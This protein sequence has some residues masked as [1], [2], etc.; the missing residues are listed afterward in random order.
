MIQSIKQFF[1]NNFS[2]EK[3]TQVPLEEKLN[4]AAAA[5]LIE[6]SYSDMNISE[7]ENKVLR[8]ILKEKFH[9]NETLVDELISLAEEEVRSSHCSFE[10]TRLI[11]AYF[12]KEEKF[13]L[14]QSMWEV[15]YADNELDCYEEAMIRKLADLLYVPHSDFIRAKLS[16]IQE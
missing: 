11:N 5:L 2:S 10:F 12:E 8:K 15:A 1:E 6:I 9:V 7:Q 3:K 4:L 14:I 13:K 16:V